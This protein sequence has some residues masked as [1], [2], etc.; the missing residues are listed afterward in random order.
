MA[1]RE[2][3]WRKEQAEAGLENH[4]QPSC[5]ARPETL[6]FLESA[7]SLKSKRTWTLTFIH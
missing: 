1:E 7:V 5:S 6:T 4:P 2:W 3:Q